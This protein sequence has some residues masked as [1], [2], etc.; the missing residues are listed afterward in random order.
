MPHTNCGAGK[1]CDQFMGNVSAVT[2][3]TKHDLDM[4]AAGDITP[5]DMR[6]ITCEFRSKCCFTRFIELLSCW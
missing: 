5:S 2:V 3:R 4:S 1:Y 6:S